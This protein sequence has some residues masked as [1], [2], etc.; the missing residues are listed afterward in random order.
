M[1][2]PP[3][4]VVRIEILRELPAHEPGFLALR[5]QQ[6]R[7][8]YADG[9]RSEPFVYDTVARAA[10]D[11]VVI[12]AHSRDE[13]GKRHVFLRS[14]LR[15]PI[16]TRADAA[17][18]SRE[19]TLLSAERAVLWEMPAGLVEPE[20]VGER[21]LVRCAVRELWEEVGIRATADAFQR[22]GPP[23][24]VEP[25][26]IGEQHHYFEIPVDP[27]CRERPA[28]DGSVLEQR[29]VVAL[30]AVDEALELAAR[31]LIVD[32]KT[33][34]ALRRLAELPASR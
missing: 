30:V 21:G 24:F 11:A 25:G 4:P 32:T 23:L 26:T 12:V 14:A 29:G 7:L 8:W 15:P 27:G 10:L 22:L 31:G 33:E 1:P 34:L 6:M 17:P 19:P 18:L 5:R 16:A 9:S 2:L 13:Q 3:L 20:E 28:E